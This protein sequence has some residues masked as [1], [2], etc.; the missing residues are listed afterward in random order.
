M[1]PQGKRIKN[2]LLFSI[3]ENTRR[4]FIKKS[5]LLSGAAGLSILLPP[6]I[7]RALAIDPQPGSTYLDAEHV[8]ILMQENRS[9][10]HCF[11]TLQGVR[12]FND[13][14]AMS[15]PDGNPVWLQSNAERKTYAPFRLDIKG[16]K[17]TW[18]GPLPHGRH[19]QVDA[20]NGGK[21]DGWLEAKKSRR[22]K[23]YAY[24]PLT[25]G[26]YTRQDIPFNYAFA[27]AFTVC[28][29]N[30]CS[31]NTSTFP[32]RLYLM[33]GTIRDK[34]GHENQAN[35][36]NTDVTK[37]G[38]LW[39]TFPEVLEKN[40]I[41]WRI[42]QND[43]STGGGY[44]GEE[45]SWLANFNCNVIEFFSRYNV[46]FNSR[47]I[48]SITS[49]NK[50]L[51][52]QIK[53]LQSK[54]NGLSERS[55]EYQKTQ[56]AIQ[57]KQKVLDKAARNLIK[58]TEENF[59]KLSPEEKNLYNKAFTINKNDPDY[60][61]LTTL[62]YDDEGKERTVRIPKGDILHQFRADVNNGKLPAVSWLVGS[63]KVS[64]HPSEPWYGVWYVSEILDILTKNPEVWKKTIF[65][66]TYDE[67][68]GYFDHVP[69]FTPPSPIHPN[70]GKTSEG[71]DIDTEFI[72]L[73]DELAAGVPKK[74]ARQAPI[75]LGYR[76]PMIIASPWSRG[77]KVC[78]QVFDHTSSLQFL[79]G[80]LG[81]KTGKDIKCHNISQWR[82][83]ICGDLTTVFRP[84]NPGVK[85]SKI[86]FLSRDGQI[87]N[88][89]KAQFKDIPSG[90]KELTN[91]ETERVRQ[92]DLSVPF[93]PKQE[94]GIRTACALP[95][96][97]Q[98]TGK[99][100]VDKKTFEINLGAGNTMFGKRSAGAPF[101]IYAPDKYQDETSENG[102]ET[103]R[104]WNY[105]VVPGD[106]VSDEW[107][108]TSFEGQMYH[109]RTYAPNGF[110]REFKG[111]SQDPEIQLTTV[112]ERHTQSGKFTGNL[113]LHVENLH[114]EKEYTVLINDNAY[115][116]TAIQKKVSGQGTQNITLNLEK[117]FGW[118][119]FS[120]RIAGFDTFEQRFAGH[121]ETG[122]DTFT[123]P[124]MGRMI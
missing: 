25:M 24:L 102:F 64:D 97:L 19:D 59:K 2:Q 95:Y 74:D 44:K 54:L 29:H 80:F 104:S 101:K 65:I 22:K 55:E 87:E 63:S 27:D 81:A 72:R 75:G 70:S 94:P 77:G 43:L 15:L 117:S 31:G 69:P 123:D 37:G 79:E 83:T 36:R 30:F 28:D 62:T 82:R 68:D 11:G 14:R 26:Y 6:S 38:H 116:T 33:S 13:P 114:K 113:I 121:V 4:E 111:N 90:F 67:N 85:D 58:Y 32:N 46:Q 109:L 41:S 122:E 108:I 20:G 84:Y 47:Y 50:K 78:S 7:Q 73:E 86:S 76:V 10:D 42:Y 98:A 60:D 57:A 21:H 115:K 48:R 9:F 61:K 56:T 39:E 35:I 1:S 124:F 96:Q 12:G 66:L 110:Y 103:A 112:E 92:G 53:V 17:A 34:P 71:I 51:P 5:L 40:G 118:Y 105:A 8:V 119:D 23:E 89:H 49:Q 93:M 45:K 120:V 91:A 107:A 99:L 100:S 3:M 106:S 16:S 52:G 18:M 88:I